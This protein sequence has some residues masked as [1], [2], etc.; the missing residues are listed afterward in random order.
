MD[1]IC[2]DPSWPPSTRRGA[3]PAES[4]GW[5][6][7]ANRYAPRH[8]RP[9]SRR[10][11]SAVGRAAPAAEHAPGRPGPCRPRRP[12]SFA[13]GPSAA[14]ARRGG[15]D[16]RGEVAHLRVD[17]RVVGSGA[18]VAPADDA[19]LD[20]RVGGVAAEHRATRVALAGVRTAAGV[21]GADL[22]G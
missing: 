10:H 8:G 21:A 3:R 4:V 14:E 18:T 20:P 6:T 1:R 17:A 11:H 13:S 5:P 2:T 7:P 12:R 22:L 16:R 9:A 19:D 15:G